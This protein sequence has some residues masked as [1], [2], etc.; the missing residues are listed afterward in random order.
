MLIDWSFFFMILRNKIFTFKGRSKMIIDIENWQVFHEKCFSKEE[1]ISSRRTH[2]KQSESKIPELDWSTI[3]LILV[4]HNANPVYEM[5]INTLMRLI[6]W[7]VK[8]KTAAVP[9]DRTTACC[10]W[11]IQSRYP[12]LK[13]WNSSLALRRKKRRKFLY[14]I[15]D[16]P[17][18]RLLSTTLVLEIVVL[19]SFS[20]LNIFH[21]P[22]DHEKIWLWS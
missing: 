15:F 5:H 13:T 7:C 12:V 10:N 3:T 9:G 17:E 8:L 22:E 2:R 6:S 4:H 16:I 19:V 14:S 1:K 20:C 11:L 21:V 18:L